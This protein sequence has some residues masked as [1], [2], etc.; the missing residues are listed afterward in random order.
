MTDLQIK[1]LIYENLWTYFCLK[2]FF[3][4]FQI[5]NY[6]VIFVTYFKNNN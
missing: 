4:E 6:Y 3:T 5:F 1:S 2:L